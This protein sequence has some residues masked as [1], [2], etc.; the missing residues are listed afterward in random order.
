MKVSKNLINL[1]DNI[2]KFCNSRNDILE[3]CGRIS[4]NLEYRPILPQKKQVQN[5]VN[6]INTSDFLTTKN[7]LD[8][9]IKASYELKW[10]TTYSENEVG[11]DF[12][13]DMAGST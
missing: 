6:K 10:N 11:S 7:I 12:I 5:L 13:K 2:I 9:I 4:Q 1:K 3:F 8:S